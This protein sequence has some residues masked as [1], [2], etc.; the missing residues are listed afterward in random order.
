MKKKRKAQ[1][2]YKYQIDHW[3]K[4][5]NQLV[6]FLMCIS[7]VRSVELHHVFLLY[8][9]DSSRASV[10][11]RPLVGWRYNSSM[12]YLMLI[13]LL[14]QHNVGGNQ[15]ECC[16]SDRQNVFWYPDFYLNHHH[17]IK[18]NKM[19]NQ[20]VSELPRRLENLGAEQAVLQM[21]NN[22]IH[23]IS[24]EQQEQQTSLNENNECSLYNIVQYWTEQLFYYY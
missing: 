4:L 22:K 3:L 10:L 1:N 11:H 7:S 17:H 23:D 6:N 21:K 24:K 2:V 14:R 15:R 9:I 19:L 18:S 8:L 12:R 5:T 20:N 16:L 13:L